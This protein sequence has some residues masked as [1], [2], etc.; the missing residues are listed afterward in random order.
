M[1]S[2]PLNLSLK[3]PFGATFIAPLD[4]P[5]KITNAGYVAN[6]GWAVCDVEPV[7]DCEAAPVTEPREVIVASG[8]REKAA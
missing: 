8:V 7:L 2:V 6:D 4:P 3:S 5:A 1:P